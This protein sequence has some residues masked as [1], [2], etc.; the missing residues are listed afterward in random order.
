MHKADFKAAEG[1]TVIRESSTDAFS[2]VP[3]A[4]TSSWSGFLEKIAV[5]YKLQQAKTGI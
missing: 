2:S 1:S 3:W 5:R 4:L